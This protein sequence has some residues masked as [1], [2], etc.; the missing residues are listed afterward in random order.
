MLPNFSVLVNDSPSSDT[1]SHDDNDVDDDD[2]DGDDDNNQNE[3]HT[4]KLSGELR[5]SKSPP[6]DIPSQALA[7]VK[8]LTERNRQV[9]DFYNEW[10]LAAN[11]D[12]DC[13]WPTDSVL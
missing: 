1:L 4:A 12:N 2:D 11:L 6:Q 5:I 8:S 7:R 3:D 9:G 10:S 13:S